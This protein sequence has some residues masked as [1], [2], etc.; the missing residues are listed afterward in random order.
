MGL[1]LKLLQTDMRDSFA[2]MSVRIDNIDTKTNSL[3]TK[4]SN[5]DINVNERID[6]LS[7]I[8]DA[9]AKETAYSFRQIDQRF[10]QLLQD[11]TTT[12]SPYCFN[13]E[14]MLA[15]HEERITT[16]ESKH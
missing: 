15:N 5:L 10:D 12:L 7:R 8:L 13:I 2:K 9:H 16:L 4:V 3:G 1:T 6:G 11:I 14:Q